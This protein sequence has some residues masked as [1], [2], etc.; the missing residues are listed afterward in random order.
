MGLKIPDLESWIAVDFS[1]A[2]AGGDWE[3]IPSARE[4]QCSKY[5]RWK[6]IFIPWSLMRDEKAKRLW[7]C[8]LLSYNGVRLQRSIFEIY[9]SSLAAGKHE[10]TCK[11]TFKYRSWLFRIHSFKMWAVWKF[12]LWVFFI[13]ICLYIYKNTIS[14]ACPGCFV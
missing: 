2:W 13:Y 1:S 9:R 7:V 5:K 12:V 14:G 3:E 10:G 8:K 4:Q 6:I 11:K